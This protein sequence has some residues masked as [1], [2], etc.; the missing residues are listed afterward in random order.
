MRTHLTLIQLSIGVEVVRFV[1]VRAYKRH[2]YGKLEI[3]RSH[4]QRYC[5]SLNPGDSIALKIPG[6]ELGGRD[7]LRSRSAEDVVGVG[8][9]LKVMLVARNNYVTAAYRCVDKLENVFK[10]GAGQCAGVFI[11]APGAV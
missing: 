3:V 6:D 2:R 8:D 5:K 9:F 10:V 11:F 4:Y 1:R 7:Y